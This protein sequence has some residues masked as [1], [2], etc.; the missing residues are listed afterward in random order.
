[1][2]VLV[3]VHLQHEIGRSFNQTVSLTSDS[4]MDYTSITSVVYDVPDVSASSL[5]EADNRQRYRIKDIIQR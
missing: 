4:E 1:M 2:Y 5:L 3:Q